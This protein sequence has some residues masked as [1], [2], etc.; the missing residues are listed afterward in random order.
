MIC[1]FDIETVPDVELLK[2]IY[3]YEGSNLEICE[4]AFNAQQAV[5]NSTFLPLCFHKVIS[6]ASVIADDFGNFKKV[7][8]FG[9]GASLEEREE[10]ILNEFASFLNKSNPRLISFNG[11]GFDLPVICLRAMKY[12]ISLGAYY[13]ESNPALNKSK[14]ENYRQRYSE[15]FHLD[16]FDTLG[17]FGATR[18]LNLD[19]VCKM[20]NIM[21]KY[22]VAGGDVYKLAYEKNDLDSIDIYCQSDV[23]NTYWLFLK[24]E[25]TKSNLTLN[26]YASYLKTMQSSIPQTLNF[27]KSLNESINEELKKIEPKL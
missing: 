2:T 20:A 23:I 18:A 11:R 6:I 24:Y 12:N 14:W 7:G 1:V 19:T 21:G 10:V 17:S 9:K 8:S 5:S 26:D 16:L 3:K 4:L 15:K 22:E 27:S 25:L 13:E